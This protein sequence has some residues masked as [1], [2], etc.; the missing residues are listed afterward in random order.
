MTTSSRRPERNRSNVNSGSFS[1]WELVEGGP[2]LFSISQMFPYEVMILCLRPFLIFSY[3]FCVFLFICQQVS[4]FLPSL[5]CSEFFWEKPQTIPW[6]GL[7]ISYLPGFL[8]I[9]I[10][11]YTPLGS[12]FRLFFKTE[13][14][15]LKRKCSTGGFGRLGLERFN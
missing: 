2:L 14:N 4:V 8:L 13:K 10:L 6:S 5:G 7:G 15:G 11:D 3:L 9:D 1:G 12:G